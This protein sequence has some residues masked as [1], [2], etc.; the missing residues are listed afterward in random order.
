[1]ATG[2]GFSKSGEEASKNFSD[3]WPLLDVVVGCFAGDDDVVHMALAETGAGDAH[4]LRPLLQFCNGSTA[5]VAHPRSKAADKLIDH[6]FEWSAI[7]NATFNS[8]GNKFGEAILAGALPLHD[9]F[10]AEL[11]AGQIVGTLEIAF[12]GALAHGGQ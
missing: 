7:G 12:A 5:K 11:G 4:K 2:D 6:G 9:T 8:F 1:M 10:C 3:R